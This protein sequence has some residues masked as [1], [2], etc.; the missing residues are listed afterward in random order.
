L[1][2]LFCS[3]NASQVASGVFVNKD[4]DG[5]LKR[6]V[7]LAATR[8]SPEQDDPALFEDSGGGAA[9]LN[10]S[11]TVRPTSSTLRKISLT[12]VGGE[13]SSCFVCLRERLSSSRAL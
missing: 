10:G 2:T 9:S 4:R 11:V 8:Y 1:I 3:C 7:Y 12:S 5:A 13:V 6:M